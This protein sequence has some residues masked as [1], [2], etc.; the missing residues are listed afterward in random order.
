MWIPQDTR[1]IK[2]NVAI[3]KELYSPIDEMTLTKGKVWVK[4]SLNFL[5]NDGIVPRKMRRNGLESASDNL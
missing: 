2:K 5:G 3:W 1:Q 4:S